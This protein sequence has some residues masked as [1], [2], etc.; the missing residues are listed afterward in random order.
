MYINF[1]INYIPF[2]ILREILMHYEMASFSIY[3]H[4]V[5]NEISKIYAQLAEV[6]LGFFNKSA[7]FFGI[8]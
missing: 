2:N 6:Q 4:T 1:S 8:S 3:R 5:P 7:D